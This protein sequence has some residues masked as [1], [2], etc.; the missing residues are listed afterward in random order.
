MPIQFFWNAYID[1]NREVA[2]LL[3]DVFFLDIFTVIQLQIAFEIL[4]GNIWPILLTSY[5][6]CE[7]EN[8]LNL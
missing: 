5:S 7:L 6:Y 2:I 4:L 1:E 8:T 3:L